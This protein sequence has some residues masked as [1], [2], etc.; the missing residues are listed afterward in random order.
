L[1]CKCLFNIFLYYSLK[2]MA[3]YGNHIF[4]LG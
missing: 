3:I 2:L 1:C 4:V